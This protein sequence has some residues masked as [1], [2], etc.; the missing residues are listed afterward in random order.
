MKK[1]TLLKIA[2]IIIILLMTFTLQGT[3]GQIP[4][5]K[6]YHAGAGFFISTWGT[7]AADACGYNAEQSAL[8][9]LATTFGA[10]VA[11][12]LADG[13]G[14]GTMDIKDFRATMYGGFVG[15]ALSYAGLKIFK[16]HVPYVFVANKSAIIGLTIKF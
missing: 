4:T 14:F 7:F 1:L 11:K 12:E 10:G 16:K 5:D 2:I 15:T 6:K 3:F 9:G 13:C 8:F